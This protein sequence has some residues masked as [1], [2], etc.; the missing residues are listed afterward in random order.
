M[1][2]ATPGEIGIA[3]A[4]GRASLWLFFAMVYVFCG[5][6][7]AQGREFHEVYE[8]APNGIVTVS[9]SSGNIRISGWSENRVRVD[10]VRR[11]GREEELE[12]VRIQVTATREKIDIQTVYPFGRQMNISVDYELRVP[13]TAIL[14]PINTASGDI[15][16]LGPVQRVAAGSRSGALSA[17]EIDGAAALN[18]RSGNV[19]AIRVRG[20][21][22]VDT[23]SG[24]VVIEEAGARAYAISR[25]GNV[26]AVQVRDDITAS[27]Q[28]GSVRLEK[29]GGRAVVR[30]LSGGITINDIGGDVQAQTLSDSVTVTSARGYVSASSVSGGVALRNVAGGARA[31]SVSGSVELTDVKGRVEARTTSGGIR[32]ANVESRNLS[33]KATSGEVR[34]TGPLFEDGHYELESFSGNVILILPPDSQFNL[35]ARSHGGSIKTDFPVTL[36]QGPAVSARG[37]LT[38]VVGK[39]GAEVRASTFSGSVYL[40][41]AAAPAK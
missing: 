20:E 4:G 25:S 21:V 17:G 9:N 30:S 41:K 6:A 7:G 28:S 31:I 10:A 27:A 38:G 33:A 13:R 15:T 3:A 16:I 18:S 8:L 39:G 19:T 32:L 22:H 2:G 14:D 24:D 12:Q 36:G 34:F 37:T 23:S 1:V 26:R 11:G 40:R 29:I 5:A 35:G